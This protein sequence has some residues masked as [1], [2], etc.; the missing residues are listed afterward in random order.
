[1]VDAK[2]VE[3]ALEEENISKAKFSELA[4]ITRPT[5]YKFFQ[6]QEVSKSSLLRIRRA[7]S[8]LGVELESGESLG[9]SPKERLQELVYELDKLTSLSNTIVKSCMSNGR[10]FTREEEL[11]EEI[12]YNWDRLSLEFDH[13]RRKLNAAVND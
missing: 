11:V 9:F 4:K 13:L 10:A 5:L 2:R 6:G 8:E 12:F 3:L 7:A 1:M